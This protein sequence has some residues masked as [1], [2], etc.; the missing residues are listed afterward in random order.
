MTQKNKEQKKLW[1]FG[2]DFNLKT[3]SNQFK[4]LPKEIINYGVRYTVF[5]KSTSSST[6][7]FKKNLYRYNKKGLH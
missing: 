5:Q 3:M 2:E 7:Q 6:S 1:N 4:L